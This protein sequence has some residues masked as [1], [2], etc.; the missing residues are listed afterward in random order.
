MYIYIYI[1]IYIYRERERERGE[2]EKQTDKKTNKTLL[3]DVINM[4]P[5]QP[6][7]SIEYF[8]MGV[9]NK[10]PKPTVQVATQNAKFL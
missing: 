3:P 4:Q 1:D 8:R 7:V 2:A 6:K 5:R 10:A 9:I